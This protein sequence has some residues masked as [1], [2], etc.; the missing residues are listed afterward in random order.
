MTLTP[1]DYL[2]AFPFQDVRPS[3]RQV[4]QNIYEA[5]NS[6]YKFVVLEAPTGF[7][8]SPLAMGVAR[9]LVSSYICSAT[10]ECRISM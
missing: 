4:L 6:G 5:F 9:T 3:Q 7:G 10:K 2:Q 8:K 1:N